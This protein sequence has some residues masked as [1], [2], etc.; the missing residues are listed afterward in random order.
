M[1][2]VNKQDFLLRMDRI[3]VNLDLMKMCATQS[4]NGMM[5]NVNLYVKN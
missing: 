5:I 4:E 3:S 2:R 1:P